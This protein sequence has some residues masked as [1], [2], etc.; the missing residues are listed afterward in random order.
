MV[1]G[2]NSKNSPKELLGDLGDLP[3]IVVAKCEVG[4][5]GGGGGHQVLGWWSR[6]GK[7]G[8]HG[9]GA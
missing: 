4:C 8:G 1:C 6:G 5:G 3:I 7:C 2:T 9:Q